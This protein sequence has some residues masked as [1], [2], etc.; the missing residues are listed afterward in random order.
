M[1]RMPISGLIASF[2][3]LLIAGLSLPRTAS[4][5]DTS[6]AMYEKGVQRAAE[7]EATGPQAISDIAGTFRVDGKIRHKTVGITSCSCYVYFYHDNLQGGDY[8]TYGQKNITNQTC[9]MNLPFRFPLGDTG[10]PVVV[11]MSANCTGGKAYRYYNAD[12]PDIPLK[13]GNSKV[14]KFDIDM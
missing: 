10:R 8:Y 1:R 12:L 14:V 3:I 11:T 7:A 5:Q 13:S 4:A 9:K 2:V 6:Q